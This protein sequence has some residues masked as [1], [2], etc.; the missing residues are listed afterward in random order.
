MVDDDD[1][2]E[3]H[4][5]E[6]RTDSRTALP[7]EIRAWRRLRIVKRDE[8]FSLVFSPR[9]GIYRVAVEFG[10]ASGGRAQGKG[11][12][13]HPHGQGVVSMALILSPVFFIFSK[14]YLRGFSGHSENF[15]F[16]HKNNTM[17]VLLKTTSVRVSFVQIMQVRVQNKG[18]SV[19]KSRYVGDVSETSEQ[20]FQKATDALYIDGCA[21]LYAS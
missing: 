12:A 11:R 3:S 2:D 15:C 4:S 10:G 14:S 5:P 17:A 21:S 7:R 1:S 6:P 8:T 18:K 19:W 16:L 13:P 20:E 9:N